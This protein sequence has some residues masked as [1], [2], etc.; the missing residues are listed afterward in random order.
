MRILFE[1]ANHSP[2]VRMLA[3]QDRNFSS[4]RE[5]ARMVQ[6]PTILFAFIRIFYRKLRILRAP[7]ALEVLKMEKFQHLKDLVSRKFF[8]QNK[9]N[10]SQTKVY[11][12]TRGVST[13]MC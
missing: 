7:K 9:Q 2:L 4:S 1:I 3:Y 8:C 13:P 12:W 5:F 11:Q 10:Q 6:K